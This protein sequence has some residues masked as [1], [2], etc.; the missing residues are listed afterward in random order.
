MMVAM[1]KGW[2]REPGRG[3]T[4]KVTVSVENELRP[5]GMRRVERTRGLLNQV[6][7]T[8]HCRRPKSQPM[9]EDLGGNSM[10]EDEEK[11]CCSN[12]DSVYKYLPRTEDT[13]LRES[14]YGVERARSLTEHL[15][16]SGRSILSMS[17]L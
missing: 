13:E 1:A 5:P 8:I 3:G 4:V 11:K 9:E 6:P 12:A 17:H 10:T 7:T 14:Q 2:R 16:E 15:R